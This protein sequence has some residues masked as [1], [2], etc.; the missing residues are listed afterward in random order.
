M[1]DFLKKNPKSNEDF[2]QLYSKVNSYLIGEVH[3]E[4]WRHIKEATKAQNMSTKLFF[5]ILDKEIQKLA[6]AVVEKQLV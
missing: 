4:M 3:Q 6:D 1:K 5:F 2:V